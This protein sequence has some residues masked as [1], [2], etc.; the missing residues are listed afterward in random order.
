MHISLD[1]AL[2]QQRR[3]NQVGESITQIAPNPAAA[4]SLRSLTGGDPRAVRIRRSSDNSEQ[5]F[6]VS[7][8]SAGA[9]VDF[10]G[11]GNDGF[12]ETW[13]DQ[14]G[15]GN[16]LTQATAS[17][18]PTIVT[19]GA[20]NTRNSQPIV[21]FIQT[22]ETHLEGVSSI[23]PT[24]TD[25]AMTVFHAMHVDTS[26]SNRIGLFGHKNAGNS[27]STNKYL[28]GSGPNIKTVIKTKDASNT[29]V[30]LQSD[31]VTSNDSDAIITY[32]SSMS[33]GTVT[34]AVF[35]LGA[36]VGSTLTGSITDQSYESGNTTILG[37]RTTGDNF[38][39]S[40][41]F[42]VI[43]YASDQLSNRNAIESNLSNK[44]G[45]SLS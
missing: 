9:L 26:S 29:V 3:L 32:L 10:V 12:V 21:K 36:Q 40:E 27:P 35:N 25:I 18:Q 30:S 23:F 1:S 42:E 39:D 31:A 19:S 20:I 38:S 4:Y 11:S 44:Y 33:N 8:I 22:N 5:D 6:T 13:Y 2:G 43:V 28:T 14:S 15:N 41:F 45:I 34:H 17:K 7:E 37:S 24:G 16:D